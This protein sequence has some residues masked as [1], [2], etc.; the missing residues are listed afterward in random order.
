M[1]GEGEIKIGSP[2]INVC[3][4]CLVRQHA[5][6][7]HVHL[8]GHRYVVAENGDILEAGPLSNGAVPAHDRAFDPRVFLDPAALEDYAP[9]EPYTVA[10]HDAG[11]DGH[12]RTDSTVLADLRRRVDQYVSAMHVRLGRRREELGVLLCQRGKVEASS[13]QEILGLTNVHPEALEIERVQLTILYDGGESLLLDRGRA[14]LDT[15]ENAGVEDV[16]TGV[17]TVSDELDRLFN[18]AV[19]ARCVSGLVHHDSVLGRLVDFGNN[20]STLLSVR[21]V[22]CRQLLERVFADYVR[23]EDEEWRV[24]LSKDLFGELEWSCGA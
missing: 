5:S 15:V 21:A 11:T 8:V 24:V 12:V 22:E 7:V 3:L 6:S 23:V 1:G 16:N 18:E 4:D 17:D 14:E 9:L 10:D 20:D 13:G 19:D 2:T